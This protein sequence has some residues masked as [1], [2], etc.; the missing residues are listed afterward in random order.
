MPSA[1]SI[2][3][4]SYPDRVIGVD[5]QL[6]WRLGT[7]LSHFKKKTE[8]HAIIMGRKTFESLGKALP[9]RINI[10]LSRSPIEE[11]A[12]VM[13]AG[14]PETALLL[15]DAHS[16]FLH[17]KEFFVIGGEKIYSIFFKYINKI[18]L[19]DVY[20]GRINGDAKFDYE[21][22][23]KDWYFPSEVEYDSSERD[24]WKFRISLIM[25]R[26]QVHRRRSKDEFLK[27]DLDILDLL[28]ER[29]EPE[30]IEKSA[31]QASLFD[32]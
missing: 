12:N 14:N 30:Q 22:S 25:R 23:P 7:D 27:V 19:T 10:V 3:A 24:E 5:N 32:E 11:T 1:T 9:N 16:I 15:A 26:K 31:S 29:I 2:V 13:W 18:W 28:E 4:R 6:P 21:F 17:Q 8:G 20:C